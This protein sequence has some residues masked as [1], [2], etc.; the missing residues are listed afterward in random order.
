[1][2]RDFV[3]R[4]DEGFYLAGSRVPLECVVREFRERQSPEAIRSD[5]PT[6]NLE[7]VHGDI[8]FYLGHR[9]K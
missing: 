6:L 9:T 5:F 8:T 7:Q 1:M 3:E 4:R 2:H